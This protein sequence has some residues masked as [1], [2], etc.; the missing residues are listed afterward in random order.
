MLQKLYSFAFPI[1]GGTIGAI[2]QLPQIQEI[3]H[4]NLI[5]DAFLVAVVGALVGYLVKRGLDWIWP[6]IF[7]KNKDI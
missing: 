3:S 6:K 4:W 2:T 5:F 7:R 1:S